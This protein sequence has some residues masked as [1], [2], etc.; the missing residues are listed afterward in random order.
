LRGSGFLA[1]LVLVVANAFLAGVAV[2][3]AMLIWALATSFAMW[4]TPR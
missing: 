3:P 1:A 2:I 4:R